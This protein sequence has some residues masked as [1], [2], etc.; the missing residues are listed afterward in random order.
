LRGVLRALF[1][2]LSVIIG[3]AMVLA[4]SITVSINMLDRN[5]GW[6]VSS[7]DVREYLLHVPESYDPDRP[8]PLVISLHAGATWPAHQKNLT[9]WNELADQHGFIVV[10]PAGTAQTFGVVRIWHT[11]QAGTGL[12]RD[13]T[14]MSELID[15]LQSTYHIDSARI[16]ANGLSNGGGLA[17]ALSCALSHRIAAVGM[18]APAQT[19]PP[20]WCAATRPVPMIAFHGD[21]DTLLP[22]G[23]GPLGDPFNPVKPVFGPI[24]DFVASWAER[25][26]CTVD[27]VETAVAADV[28]RIKYPDC[29]ADAAVQFYTIIGG[30]HTWPGGKPMQAWWVG[31]TSDSIDATRLMWAFFSEHVLNGRGQESLCQSSLGNASNLSSPNSDRSGA[32]I[33]IYRSK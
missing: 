29:A 7:D 17:F 24:R 31:H 12:E 23:G 19:L 32:S 20:D 13:I 9:R 5:N 16:Y 30:G 11:F 28:V 26:Q 3:L 21:A 15:E 33:R 8:T 27:P 10:Y 25:N 18:V 4:L 6:L 2:T 22:Y 1:G 14:F